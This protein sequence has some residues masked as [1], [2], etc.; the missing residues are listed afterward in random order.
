M[1]ENPRTAVTNFE[2]NDSAFWDFVLG[3][4]THLVDL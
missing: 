2:E 3:F 1:E 4:D